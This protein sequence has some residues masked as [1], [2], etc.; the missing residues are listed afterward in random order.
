MQQR[1][2]LRASLQSDQCLKNVRALRVTADA[3]RLS[4]TSAAC[5]ANG[6]GGHAHGG[7]GGDHDSTGQQ[8]Q[9]IKDGYMQ[10]RSGLPVCVQSFEPNGMV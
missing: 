8:F 2:E 9:S 1:T 5:P 10:V 7:T 3:Q 6:G 4:K